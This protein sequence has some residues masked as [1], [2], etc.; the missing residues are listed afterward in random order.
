MLFILLWQLL[1]A[2]DFEDAID[3]LNL[4]IGLIKQSVTGNTETSLVLIHALS[5]CLRG[6]EDQAAAMSKSVLN[7]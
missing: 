2:G 1:F 4:A 5:D 7:H 3:T 6:V